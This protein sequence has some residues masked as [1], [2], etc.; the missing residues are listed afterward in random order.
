T[1]IG[2]NAS[3]LANTTFV[4]G[5]AG[6]TDDL[7][8]MAFDGHDYSGNT[9]FS[10]FHVN[11]PAANHAPVVT[12]PSVNVTASAGQVF[13]ASSLFSVTDADN[14]ALT[15]FLF[16]WSPAANS[17]HLEVNGNVVP[18]QTVIGLNAAQLANTT[19]V[20]GSAGTTGVWGV[21][22]HGSAYLRQ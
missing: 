20:A 2:L 5:S 3:Q 12:I 4:A 16:D 10:P 17:G 11:V 7:G 9:S 6:T 22:V 21:G 15:Y 18:A 13:A 14:D 1:V 19:F 8:V